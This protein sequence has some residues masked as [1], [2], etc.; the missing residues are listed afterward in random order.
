FHAASTAVGRAPA[1]YHVRHVRPVLPVAAVRFASRPRRRVVRFSVLRSTPLGTVG[2]R[3]STRQ[4]VRGLR[5][6]GGRVGGRGRPRHG[7]HRGAQGDRGFGPAGR[8]GRGHEFR[9]H[10]GGALRPRR[11]CVGARARR[12]V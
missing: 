4:P 1:V 11:A 6:R 8:R 9:R 3:G 10:H 12:A 5:R 7:A 2:G